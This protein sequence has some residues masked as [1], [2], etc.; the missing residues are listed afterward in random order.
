MTIWLLTV[1]LLASLAG[2]GLRQGAI[3]VA[4]SFCGIVLGALLAGPLGHLVRFGLSASGLKNPIWLELLPPCIGFLIVLTIFKIVGGI[5]HHKA[6]VYYKHKASDVRLILWERVNHR[7]GLCLGLLNGAAYLVIASVAIYTLSYWTYQV[8]TP[9]SDPKTIRIVNQLGKDLQGTGMNKVATSVDRMPDAYYNAAD[10][11][12]LIYHNPLLQARLSRYPAIL[13]LAE[14]PEFQDLANDTQ[15]TELQMKQA[16]VIELIK[17]PKVQSILDNPDLIKAVSDALVPNL[18][19]LRTFLETG[20]SAKYESEK[21]LGRWDFDPNGT[22]ALLRK[23]RPN[24]PSTEM[25]Q[26]R[27]WFATGYTKTTFTATTDNKVYVKNVPKV[28]RSAGAQPTIDFQ[29]WEGSWTASGDKYQIALSIDGKDI[30]ATGD[31]QGGRLAVSGGDVN[32][33]FVPED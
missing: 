7:L 18:K 2:L 28:N 15:F 10:I 6:E 20:V 4:F 9:D 25:Q 33:V 1:L 19:D 30:Q 32:L 12:G 13:T 24:M 16:P 23:Q 11:V 26:L 8:A 22:I 14:R 27:R 29:K 5:V 21:I 31:I 17:Y 3:R